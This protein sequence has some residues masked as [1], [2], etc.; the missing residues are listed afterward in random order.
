MMRR[1]R[2]MIKKQN[3][4]VMMRMVMMRMEM[5]RMVMMRIV[6]MSK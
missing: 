3:G 6:M 1:R 5:V 2:I 4:M